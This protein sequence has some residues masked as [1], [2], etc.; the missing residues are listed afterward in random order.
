MKHG[1]SNRPVPGLPFLL[2]EA[3]ADVDGPDGPLSG[4]TVGDYR[5]VT[6]LAIGGMSEVW[7]ADVLGGPGR[8]KTAIVKRLLP[9]LRKLSLSQSPT[10][11]SSRRA[12]FSGF[13][14]LSP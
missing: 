11:C 14:F 3:E 10:W 13:S 6:R 4:A 5:L 12:P 8:G 9:K 2:S 1:G 7:L